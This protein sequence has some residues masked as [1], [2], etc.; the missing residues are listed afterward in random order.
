MVR[1]YWQIIWRHRETGAIIF[2]GLTEYSTWLDADN[3][4]SIN[5]GFARRY[6]PTIERHEVA[7]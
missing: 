2:A 1:T 5:W 7:A 3:A 6:T 4:V